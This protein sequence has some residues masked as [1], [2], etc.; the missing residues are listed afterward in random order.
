MDWQKVAKRIRVPLGFAFAIF[1]LWFAVPRLS[2]LILGGIVALLG[3]WMRAYA[4]GYVNKNESLATGGPYAFTRN[5]LYLGSVVIGL[6]F[7]IA[8]RSW[9]IAVAMVA[10]YLAIYIPVI[11]GEEAFLRSRFPEFSE[12]SAQVPRLFPRLTPAQVGTPSGGSFSSALYRKHREYNAL[13]GTL[14]MLAV[15]LFKLLRSSH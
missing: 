10:M 4:S 12:Y 13:I 7:A 1:Y 2:S 3:I 14:A 6:G 9:W 8:A 11:R 5:P 15:L